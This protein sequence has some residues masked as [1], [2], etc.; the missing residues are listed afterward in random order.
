MTNTTK[1]IIMCIISHVAWF[2]FGLVVG[3][4]T[5]KKELEQKLC[6]LKQYEYCEKEE[7]LNII[8]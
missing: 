1:L 2:M 8:K 3:Q 5:M 4:D 6:K 7:L